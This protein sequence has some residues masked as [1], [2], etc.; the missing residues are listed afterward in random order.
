MRIEAA[1]SREQAAFL[2]G[3]VSRDFERIS[4]QADEENNGHRSFP[5][6]ALTGMLDGATAGGCTSVW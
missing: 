1:C 6:D 4:A 5:V 2:I 3:V